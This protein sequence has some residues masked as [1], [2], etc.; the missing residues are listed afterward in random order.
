MANSKVA[1]QNTSQS[2]IMAAKVMVLSKK[3]V[4]IV[5]VQLEL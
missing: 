3:V 5:L 1:D 2:R 4:T